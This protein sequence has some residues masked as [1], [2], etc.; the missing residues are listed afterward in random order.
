ML[1]YVL[2]CIDTADWE[3]DVG[4]NCEDYKN[5]LW[6]ENGVARYSLVTGSE[7]NFPEDNCCLC[8]KGKPGE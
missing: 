1:N 8:G 2:E 3:D 7:S 5:K 4:F 6:C